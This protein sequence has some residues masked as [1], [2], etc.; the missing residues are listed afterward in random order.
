MSVQYVAR[1]VN[2]IGGQAS[3]MRFSRVL[4]FVVALP[5]KRRVLALPMDPVALQMEIWGPALAG[6]EHSPLGRGACAS[7][8]A[9]PDSADHHQ[10][11]QPT[12]LGC[13][14]CQGRCQVSSNCG[15][16][17]RLARYPCKPSR[18]PPR[19]SSASQSDKYEIAA[20]ALKILAKK[21]TSR[22]GSMP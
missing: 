14:P 21:L 7:Y 17:R 11:F 10:Q 1:D 13:A 19:P 12:R 3:T 8:K 20:T 2:A 6:A 16:P 4:I 15:Q 9:P 18:I 22:L 5:A